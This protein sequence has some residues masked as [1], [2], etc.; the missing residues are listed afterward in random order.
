MVNFEELKEYLVENNTRGFA[1]DIDETLSLTSTHWVRKM[2]KLFGNPEKL[3]AEE[4]ILKYRY[5]QLVPYWQTDEII[6]WA[7]EHVN[8]EDSYI[9]VPVI[10]GALEMVNE[11]SKKFPILAYLTVRPQSV[12]NIS[13]EWLKK[14]GF[15]E[16]HIISRPAEIVMEDGN[17]WK[18]GVLEELY[19]NLLGIVDDSA[20][21]VKHLSKEYKGTV[22][23]I[24]NNESPRS[25]IN[26][27]ACP[28]C[29]DV[30]QQ[31]SQIKYKKTK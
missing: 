28:K 21:L 5:T 11:I 20:G 18:A 24:S 17:K 4:I 15:P 10:E 25:D 19:P 27:I 13:K 26:V 31:I 1:L 6:K 12:I 22:L 3:T 23:L 30:I 7:N 8:S 29:E 14:N 16:A 9:D 2:Q